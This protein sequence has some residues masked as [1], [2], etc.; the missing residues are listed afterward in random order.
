LIVLE[1]SMKEIT[2]REPE[3]PL[4]ER[5]KERREYHYLVGMPCWNVFPDSMPPL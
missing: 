4:K 5:K 1:E 3:S 2:G